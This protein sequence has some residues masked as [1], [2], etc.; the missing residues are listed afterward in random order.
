MVLYVTRPGAPHNQKD[1]LK[2]NELFSLRFS[3]YLFFSAK[4]QG[5]EKLSSYSLSHELARCTMNSKFSILG[6]GGLVD[7]IYKNFRSLCIWFVGVFVN[8]TPTTVSNPWILRDM[9][10]ISSYVIQ[11]QSKEVNNVSTRCVVVFNFVIKLHFGCIFWLCIV[12]VCEKLQA[13]KTATKNPKV[14]KWN[15]KM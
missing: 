7:R 2:P 4:K 1:F 10:P 8:K 11:W 12:R 14:K 15:F 6:P 5:R 13:H 9:K 3:L